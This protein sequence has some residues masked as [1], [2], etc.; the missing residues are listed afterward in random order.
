MVIPIPFKFIMEIH[1]RQEQEDGKLYKIP[2]KGLGSRGGL[3]VENDTL[4]GN[5]SAVPPEGSFLVPA[6]KLPKKP[7]GEGLS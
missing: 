1:K 2:K 5:A 4:W 3:C 7:A 6:R